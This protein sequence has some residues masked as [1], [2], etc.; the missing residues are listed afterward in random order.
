MALGD[1]TTWDESTPTDGTTAVDIDDYNRDVRVG[2]R[3]RMNTEHE[4]P[5]SQSATSEAGM[6]KYITL[7]EQASKPSLSGTQK[8][9]VYAN[10]ANNCCYEKSDGTVVLISVGTD[11]GSSKILTN[12]A[13][14][15]SGYLIDKVTGITSSGTAGDA[16]VVGLGD[17]LTKGA[18]TTYHSTT[19]GIFI[20]NAT[21]PGGNVL[22]ARLLSDSTAT[23]TTIR[24]TGYFSATGAGAAIQLMTPVKKGHYY[25]SIVTGT[26][27]SAFF[28]EIGA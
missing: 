12:S 6:H 21:V 3:K 15:T 14:T 22:H 10:T 28:M 23:P 11:V 18:N 19:D 7:Q 20:L 25:S 16:V 1:G 13:D 4:W 5:S 27:V 8:A 17:W 2:V 26:L 9:A 24:A